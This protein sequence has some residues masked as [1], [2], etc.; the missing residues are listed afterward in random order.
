MAQIIFEK[1]ILQDQEIADLQQ[2][3]VDLSAFNAAINDVNTSINNLK[4]QHQQDVQ[5]LTDKIN[6]D[7][8]ALKDNEIKSLQDAVALLNADQNT[9]GSVDYK[10]KQALDALINGAGEAYDT[11]KEIVDYINKEAGD[12][13]NFI[14]QVQDKVNAVI[15]NA[16][17]D[18]NTLEKVEA[19]IKET[20]DRITQLQGDTS[21]S[22]S[23]VAAQ[24]PMYKVDDELPV[25]DGNKITL[26][27]V[28]V[29]DIVDRRACVYITDNN[30]NRIVKGLFTVAKDSDDTT[31]KVYVIQAPFT[32]PSDVKAQVSYFWNR[33]DNPDNSSNS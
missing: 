15:G 17:D 28:P 10:I 20:N 3:K 22:L 18:Y 19:R 8:Q 25:N 14:Q 23:D 30:G 6:S 24:I 5:T 9:E 16:S 33:K 32:L 13:T 1:D 26:T 11:L 2:N 31:G 27:Y 12:L 29:G 7:I 21:A 4:N